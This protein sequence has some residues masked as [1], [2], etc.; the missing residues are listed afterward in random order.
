M[1]NQFITAMLIGCGVLTAGADTWSYRDCVDYARDHNISLRKSQLNEESSAINLDEAKAQWQPTLDFATSHG[2]VNTPFANGYKNGYNSTYGLNA[3]WTVWNGGERENTIKRNELQTS[4]DRLNTADIMRTLE[5]DLLQVYINILYA[6][7]SIGIYEEAVKL[8]EA[9]AQRARGLME[10]GR[11]SRVDYAQLQAQYEQ[12]R[13]NLVNAKGTY[14]ARRM[15]LKKLLELG[16]DTDIELQDVEWTAEQVMAS[17][18]DMAESYRLATVTDIKLKGLE[19]EIDGSDLDIAIAKASGRPRLSLNAGIG[20]TLSVPIFNNKQ[21]KSAVA[22]A[23]VQKMNARL[24]IDQRQTELAQTVENWYIDTRSSQS[25]Y[26]AAVEQLSSAR[27]TNELTNEQFSLGLVNPVEL[28]T[29]HNNLVEA[30]HS[31]LQAKYMAM[32][33]QKMIEFY[34]TSTITLP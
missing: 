27:L 13:Y 15:E 10:A 33:G 6:K 26:E 18:P 17:L 7:E 28:M 22:R 1:R 20:T 9:Q 29:A 12:D 2:Y 21:T 11:I 23:N 30:S 32:L 34:R 24:D 4:I 16:I 25:R 8:S 5:T 31:L 3:G 14:D 19:L